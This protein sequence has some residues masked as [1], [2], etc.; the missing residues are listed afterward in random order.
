MTKNR[1]KHKIG[2]KFNAELNSYKLGIKCITTSQKYFHI[3]VV[4]A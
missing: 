3:P 1:T 4:Y 2:I